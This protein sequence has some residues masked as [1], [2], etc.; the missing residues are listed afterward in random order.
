MDLLQRNRRPTE[1][2]EQPPA[3]SRH[4]MH[5]AKTKIQPDSPMW[6]QKA[7]LLEVDRLI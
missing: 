1:R 3:A 7:I 4:M 5:L 6:N 2:V